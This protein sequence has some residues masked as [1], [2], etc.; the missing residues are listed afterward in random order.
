MK[1]C[2]I[3][4]NQFE[5]VRAL[6]V[7]CSYS[8][9]LAYSRGKIAKVVKAENKVK[10]ERMKTKSQHLKELQ[11]IFNKYIRLRDLLLPCV[12]CGDTINSTAHASHF[13][14][15]GSHPALRFNEDNVHSSCEQCN[16]Y[17]HGNLIEYSLRLPERIGQDNY[18]NLIASRGERLQL[19]IPEI[20]E[21]KTVY[22]Q[23]I[24]DLI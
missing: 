20:E 22:K 1:T 13:F 12:S 14:S 8:C 3:C 4:F 5:P 15:V 9:A 21:L 6:M 19:S 24:K 23:K 16:T 11:T 17:L 10:K 2:K 18:D 7:T